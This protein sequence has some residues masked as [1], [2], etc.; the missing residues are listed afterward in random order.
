MGLLA[1]KVVRGLA[2]KSCV[3]ETLDDLHRAILNVSQHSGLDAWDINAFQNQTRLKGVWDRV[4]AGITDP[5]VNAVIQ[6][7]ENE[8]LEI[9]IPGEPRF[10]QFTCTMSKANVSAIRFLFDFGERPIWS[11]SVVA[12]DMFC[13]LAGGETPSLGSETTPS[14]TW[15]QFVQQR[16][17]HHIQKSMQAGLDVFLSFDKNGIGHVEAKSQTQYKRS[18]RSKPADEETVARIQE[19]FAK[20]GPDQPMPES[21]VEFWSYNRNLRTRVVMFVIQETLTMF[22]RHCAT[23]ERAPLLWLD[24]LVDG[25]PT[26][27]CAFAPSVS[28]VPDPYLQIFLPTMSRVVVSESMDNDLRDIAL[29][30]DQL[31]IPLFLIPELE[32]NH[33]ESDTSIHACMEQ[34]MPY[35]RNI[36]IVSVDTD[37]CVLGPLLITKRNMH[38]HIPF[39]DEYAPVNVFLYLYRS[40]TVVDC[41]ECAREWGYDERDTTLSNMNWGWILLIVLCGTDFV[42]KCLHG[43]SPQTILFVYQQLWHEFPNLS[44]SDCDSLS[45]ELALCTP[46]VTLNQNKF[47]LDDTRLLRFFQCVVSAAVPKSQAYNDSYGAFYHP[48]DKRKISRI[49]VPSKTEIL[50]TFRRALYNLTYWFHTSSHTVEKYVPHPL[51]TDENGR[52]LCGWTIDASSE[53]TV[54]SS[55]DPIE[56]SSEYFFPICS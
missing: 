13:Y 17:L 55:S 37:Q 43:V 18:Q 8:S 40:R 47:V 33:Y 3:G 35:Y 27:L 26:V 4:V 45:R 11:R 49:V 34:L 52:S 41:L 19:E 22:A 24:T 48:S 25:K 42:E 46:F 36:G 15:A 9:M 1:N 39:H 32:N 20:I 5:S 31:G 51:S 2:E 23:A 53:R 54:S 16:V 28:E 10:L 56:E 14:T 12:Y 44:I 7:V 21:W 50:W 30:A 6:P 29:C 38:K